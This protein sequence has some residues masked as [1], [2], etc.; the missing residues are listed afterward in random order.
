[1]TIFREFFFRPY[2]TQGRKS[3]IFVFF[4]VAEAVRTHI[5]AKCVFFYF[6][7]PNDK[8]YIFFSRLALI[9]GNSFNFITIV[10]VYYPRQ[11]IDRKK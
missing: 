7:V 6:L 3:T 9:L 8:N 5:G 11:I 4:A 1:M 10:N 2:G